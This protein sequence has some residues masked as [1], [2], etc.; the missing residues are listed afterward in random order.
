M[1]SCGVQGAGRVLG[2]ADVSGGGEASCVP[3]KH[4]FAKCARLMY[5]SQCLFYT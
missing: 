1:I 4:L 5:G 3:G 2:K